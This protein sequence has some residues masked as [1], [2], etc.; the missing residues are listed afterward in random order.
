MTDQHK[1]QMVDRCIPKSHAVVD[2]V[3]TSLKVEDR[4]VADV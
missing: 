4:G 1:V 2:V 3:G